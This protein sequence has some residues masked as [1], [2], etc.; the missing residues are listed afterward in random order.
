MIITLN[1]WSIYNSVED[2]FGNIVMVSAGA[3]DASY[4]FIYG[5]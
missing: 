5:V 1:K 3:W 2:G 4:Y